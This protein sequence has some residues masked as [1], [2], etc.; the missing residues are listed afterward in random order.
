MDLWCPNFKHFRVYPD[1]NTPNRLFILFYAVCSLEFEMNMVQIICKCK[2]CGLLNTVT[3]SNIKIK[4][5]HCCQY[6]VWYNLGHVNHSM[7]SRRF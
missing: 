4:Q 3:L 6:T 2:L 5:N 7:K 1:D